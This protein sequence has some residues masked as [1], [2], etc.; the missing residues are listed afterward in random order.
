MKL[1]KE[2]IIKTD[3]FNPDLISGFLWEL[4][5]S[6]INEEQDSLKIFSDENNKLTKDRL[7]NHLQKLIDNKIISSFEIEELTLEEKNW[8]EEWEKEINIVE[9]SD[10]IVIKPSFKNYVNKQNKIVI[11]IDPKMSFGTG[12]HQTTRLVIRLLEKHIKSKMRVL[13]V[14]TGTGILAIASAKLGA[15]FVLAIDNDEWCF[16]NAK[17]NCS[18]NDVSSNVKIKLSEIEEVEEN[19]FDLI[20]ANIQ[21]DILMNIADEIKKRL[22]KKGI[23]I[24]SGLLNEDEKSI[25]EKYETLD[26][27]FVEKMNMDEWLALVFQNKPV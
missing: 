20:L 6:G 24:L 1:Y 19:N 16:E 18:L 25:I 13:D 2:F 23:V 7:N 26:L 11:T 5:I 27:T 17:E 14:G 21:K 12:E 10:N 4:N 3:P 22:I 8:N 9:V 15:D